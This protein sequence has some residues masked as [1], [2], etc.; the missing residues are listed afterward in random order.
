VF[1]FWPETGNLQALPL[2]P[3]RSGI[4]SGPSVRVFPGGREALVVGT[5]LPEGQAHAAH[6]YIL[7]FGDQQCAPAAYPFPR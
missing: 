1:R 3:F 6:L 2:G 7:R 5:P 4:Y